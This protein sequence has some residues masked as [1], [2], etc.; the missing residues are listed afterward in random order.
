M[1]KRDHYD[2]LD[3]NQEEDVQDICDEF[4]DYIYQYGVDAVVEFLDDD[5][6]FRLEE[7]FNDDYKRGRS[8]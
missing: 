2:V 4:G 7:Y 3:E 5:T 8:C 1:S 6:Y